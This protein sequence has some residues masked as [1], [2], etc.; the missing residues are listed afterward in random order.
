VATTKLAD[1]MCVSDFKA[2]PTGFNPLEASAR[3]LILYGYP[4]RPQNKRQLAMWEKAV[5]QDVRF[6]DPVFRLR[7]RSANKTGRKHP[8]ESSATWSGMVKHAPAGNAFSWVSGTWA[9]PAA[10]PPVGAE[11]YG[12]Y[13]ASSW[14]GIDGEVGTREVLQTGVDSSVLGDGTATTYS[15]WWEWAPVPSYYIDSLHLSPGDEVTGLIC[16]TNPTEAIVFFV[17]HGLNM[18]THFRAT[19]PPGMNLVG[20]SAEWIVERVVDGLPRYDPVIFTG[21]TAGGRGN[22]LDA[23][24]GD[25]ISMVVGGATISVGEHVGPD[26]VRVRY[27]G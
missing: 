27:T 21:A 16:V 12:T 18:A 20:S 8:P 3:E 10:H 25:V 19:A 23:N 14:V 26:T 7:T 15:A 13:V 2:P 9:V 4:A 22:T 5:A 17:V 24:S 11:P 1:G 6:V